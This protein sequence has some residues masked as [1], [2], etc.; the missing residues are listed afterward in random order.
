MDLRR[1]CPSRGLRASSNMIG[2]VDIKE[3][4]NKE[5]HLEDLREK[6]RARRKEIIVYLTH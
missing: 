2:I 1:P 3:R 6:I 4:L 5:K